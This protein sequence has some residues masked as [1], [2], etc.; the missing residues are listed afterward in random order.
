MPSHYAGKF[1]GAELQVRLLIEAILRRNGVQLTYLARNVD[2]DFEDARYRVI[3]IPRIRGMGCLGLWPD[4]PKLLRLLRRE[5]PDLIYQ[6]VG[7]AYTGYAAIYAQKAGI[8]L[9][10]HVSID[11][12]LKRD[13]GRFSSLV[14]T[15]ER[16]LRDYGIGRA[17]KIVTQSNDQSR[18]LLER[19]NRN[20]TVIGNF[21]PPAESTLAKNSKFTVVWVANLKPA[22]RPELFL[23]IVRQFR[24][25]D[26]VEF[27]MVGRGGDRPP[28]RERLNECIRE[29]DGILSYLGELS[30]DS[31]NRHLQGAHVF[32]NTS[33]DEGFPNTLI[34][35]WFHEVAVITLGID[36]DH[37]LSR[38]KIGVTVDSA[39][40]A[41]HQID[42]LRRHPAEW[43]AMVSRASLYVHDNHGL[44]N[45]DRLVDLL[46]AEL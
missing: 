34:Q 1:G 26:D 41:A 10:W 31:V 30:F 4:G 13:I 23:D 37:V 8:P 9:V 22:K 20:S 25:R 3:R 19:Y 43:R 7:C 46:M 33:K 21:Q 40:D 15:I 24:G 27:L 29:C 39:I 38:H 45:A 32:V 11:S 12:D 18:M 42:Q 16:M 35:S 6:R 28:Y 2:P 44:A 14:A 17:D 5:R 36:P